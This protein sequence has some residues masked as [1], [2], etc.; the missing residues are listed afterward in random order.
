MQPLR[1]ANGDRP[2]RGGVGGGG[3]CGIFPIGACYTNDPRKREGV[4]R[5]R[6]HLV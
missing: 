5:P 6:L 1:V 2:K 4:R 3:L